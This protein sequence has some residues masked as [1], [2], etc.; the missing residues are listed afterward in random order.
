MTKFLALIAVAALMVSDSDPAFAGRRHRNCCCRG[1]FAQAGWS[2]VQY[3]NG[4]ANWSN[5]SGYYNGQGGGYSTQGQ[6]GVTN[7]SHAPPVPVTTG[8]P[9][10]ESSLDVNV[11]PSRR[12]NAGDTNI[13]STIRTNAGDANIN[14]STR[15]N[16]APSGAAVRQG[17]DVKA[18][19]GADVKA[20]ADV[21]AKAPQPALPQQ[22]E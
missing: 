4:Q 18:A 2:G 5:N 8:Y 14:S 19:Q 13:N 17:A 6:I 15:G 1:Q 3:G 7:D 12:T 20:D 11:D 22:N 10:N 21:K 9:P 16:V